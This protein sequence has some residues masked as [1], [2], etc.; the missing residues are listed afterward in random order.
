MVSCSYHKNIGSMM[1]LVRTD[2]GIWRKHHN[3]LQ[4]RL[5]DLPCDNRNTNSKHNN[6]KSISE[7]TNVRNLNNNAIHNHEVPT[8]SAQRRYPV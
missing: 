3:Q 5:Y 4:P 7:Q 1:Y 8:C 6:P 2:H